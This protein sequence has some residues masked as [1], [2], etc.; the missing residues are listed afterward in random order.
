[1][2]LARRALAVITLSLVVAGCGQV[3]APRPDTRGDA[4]FVA[5]V[6]QLCAQTKPLVA[7]DVAAGPAATA[8]AARANLSNVAIVQAGII[9]LTPS[10]SNATPLAPTITDLEQ[11]LVDAQKWYQKAAK[12]LKLKGPD[13]VSRQDLALA[14]KISAKRMQQAGADLAKLGIQSCFA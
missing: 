14:P 4:A 5:A 6:K 2:L 1:M 12:A 8:A 13:A 10:L 7:L 3:S 11:M 9:T